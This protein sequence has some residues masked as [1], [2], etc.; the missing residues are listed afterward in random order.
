MDKIKKTALIVLG[1][2]SLVLGILGIVLPLLPTTPLLLLA[3]GCYL[4]SSDK[5]YETLINN[6]YLG[7]Y[8]KNYQEKRAIPRKAKVLALSL[9]WLSIGSSIIFFIS[10]TF[11]KVMLIIVASIVTI[12]ILKLKTIKDEDKQ[13]NISDEYKE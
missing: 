3:A 13:E 5:L 9:L 1:S 10:K 11:V 8:I 2:L 4:R 6:R 12:H 7:S